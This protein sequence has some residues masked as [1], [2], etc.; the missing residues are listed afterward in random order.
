MNYQSTFTLSPDPSAVGTWSFDGTLLPH[1]VAQMYYKTTQR[2]AAD[3]DLGTIGN[4]L[5]GQLS[6]STH[7]AKYVSWKGMFQRWRLA[8]LAVTC[9]QDG[10]DLANQGSITVCQSPIKPRVSH[11]AGCVQL[12]SGVNTS[13][14]ASIPC[15]TY[16]AEDYPNFDTSQA[17]PNA[18][19]NRSKEGAYVPLKLTKTCQQWHSESDDVYTL[20]DAVVVFTADGTRWVP[21]ASANS[22]RDTLFPFPSLNPVF[23]TASAD[24]FGLSNMSGQVTT[25]LANDVVGHISARNLAVTTSFTFFVRSGWECQVV[26]SSQLAPQLKLSPPY[27]STALKAYFMI[28]REL[29]DSYPADYNDAGKIWGVISS[30]AKSIAPA[31]MGIPMVG[32]VLSAAVPMIAGVG[33]SIRKAVDDRKARKNMTSANVSSV[34]S[35]AAVERAREE[36]KPRRSVVVRRR[37]VARAIRIRKKR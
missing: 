19:F 36:I 26:P 6:G 25:P 14:T 31:L 8:Y 17:M 18:Y 28:A 21:N 2:S 33:D 20:K 1:P 16:T 35:E 9:H 3:A 10:P 22:G 13:M 27:D 37:P 29:K 15:I 23:A 24:S 5:N 34:V 7:S 11:I 30:I 4:F 12:A 32:P